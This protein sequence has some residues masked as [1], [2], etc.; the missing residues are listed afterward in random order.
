MTVKL[1]TENHLEFLSL[2]GGCTGSSESTL[3]KCHIVGNHRFLGRYTSYEYG[4]F[5]MS[6]RFDL[7]RLKWENV[8]KRATFDLQRLKMKMRTI[9]KMITNHRLCF[10]KITK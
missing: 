6:V 5:M 2:K 8:T 1:L 9:L 7:Q 3:V 10:I 4:S